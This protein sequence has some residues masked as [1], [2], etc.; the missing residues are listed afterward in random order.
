[1]Y[2]HHPS[3]TTHARSRTHLT[4]YLPQSV[5]PTYVE[6]SCLLSSSISTWRWPFK[7]PKHVVDLYVVNSIYISTNNKVV[8]DK[9]I[10]L[11]LVRYCS[12]AV[13]PAVPG[14]TKCIL[15]FLCVTWHRHWYIW[16]LYVADIYVAYST[17]LCHLLISCSTEVTL[18]EC[19][20]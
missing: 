8:F 2:P 10:H 18:A 6:Y 9:D 7:G 1:M 4:S 11:I 17:T 12:V 13:W 5:Q 15:M 14:S 19:T 20:E 3:Y 16:L